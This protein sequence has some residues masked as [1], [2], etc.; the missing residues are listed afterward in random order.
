MKRLIN[1]YS[2]KKDLRLIFDSGSKETEIVLFEFLKIFSEIKNSNFTLNILQKKTTDLY[3]RIDKFTE[4]HK[5]DSKNFF[6]LRAFIKNLEENEWF[7]IMPFSIPN[8]DKTIEI[9]TSLEFLNQG[10]AIED[11]PYVSE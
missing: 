11:I 1:F 6:K 10:Y 3:N 5:N 2:E 9:K 8:L 4:S 7:Y